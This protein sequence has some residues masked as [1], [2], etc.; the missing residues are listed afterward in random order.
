M[1]L[2]LRSSCCCPF[3]QSH[4]CMA[5]H[6]SPTPL[7]LAYTDSPYFQA[8]C[9]YAFSSVPVHPQLAESDD[10][11]DNRSIGPMAHVPHPSTSV[12]IAISSRPPWRALG[13]RLG[14]TPVSFPLPR[15]GSDKGFLL[16]LH[17]RAVRHVAGAGDI[18]YLL[19]STSIWP[20]HL[21][22]SRT[23]TTVSIIRSD[24]HHACTDW[25]CTS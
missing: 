5:R 6:P 2:A 15:H 21:E 23:D 17:V 12:E 14:R 24:S 22:P 18:H 10:S 11:H 8:F 13:R 4:L 9:H 16:Q 7:M 1:P 20:I 3:L 25:N 19:P